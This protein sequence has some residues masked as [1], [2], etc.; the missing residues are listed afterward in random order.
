MGSLTPYY[1]ITF[2]AAADAFKRRRKSDSYHDLCMMPGDVD[3]PVVF[4]GGKDYLPLF[5]EL[6]RSV[7]SKRIVFYNSAQA[8]SAPGCSI[9][10]FNTAT[11]TNWH[12]ECVEAILAGR[13]GDC[14]SPSRTHSQSG[15]WLSDP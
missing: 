9:V 5:C 11:R 8:P 1:D 13:L 12:Y 7:R 2:S 6:T 15:E 4:F 3:E 10:R 14:I